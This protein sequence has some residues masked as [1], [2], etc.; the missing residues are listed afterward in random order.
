MALSTNEAPLFDGTY[1]S[2]SR[3]NM[4]Q[5]LKSRGSGVWDSVVSNPWNLTTS[6]NLSKF[7]SQRRVRNKNEVALKILLN[8]LSYTVKQ[9]M[10]LCTSAKELW[11]KLEKVYQIK[12]ED[13]YDIP[14]KNEKEDSTINKGKDSPQYSDCSNVD[15]E[16]SPASKEEDS[17]TIEEIFV[18]FIPWK[19]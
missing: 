10:G 15:M 2:S 16:F 3:D 12:K 4:K 7:A 11:L 18:A 5:Y 13:T 9:S 1:Y 19:K 8:G 6:K 17:D 14:I